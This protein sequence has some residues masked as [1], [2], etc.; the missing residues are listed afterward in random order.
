MIIMKRTQ[1]D[2]PKRKNGKRL[3]FDEDDLDLLELNNHQKEK[4]LSV[5]GTMSFGLLNAEDQISA[6]R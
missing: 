2:N 4:S 6:I 5:A 1:F 3:I